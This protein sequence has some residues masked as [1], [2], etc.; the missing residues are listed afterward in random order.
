MYSTNASPADS[1]LLVD[2]LRALRWCDEVDESRI[3]V[4]VRRGIVTLTGVVDWPV[5]RVAAVRAVRDVDGVLAVVNRIGV[6]TDPH[7]AT[8]AE[9][10]E[11]VARTLEVA[12][13]IPATVRAEVEHGVVV[14][15]GEVEFEAQAE[16]ARRV[17]ERIRGVRRV[18]NRL[19][20]RQ[21]R[22]QPL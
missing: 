5:E 14:L 10:K 11:Q 6:A 2:V 19:R 13:S 16:R 18:E 17:L 3:D 21:A 7:T 15:T 4:T 8:D 1:R 22:Q 9:I 12:S 20:V